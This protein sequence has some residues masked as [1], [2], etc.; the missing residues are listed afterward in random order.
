MSGFSGLEALGAVFLASAAV[1]FFSL[2]TMANPW[3]ALGRRANGRREQRQSR[4]SALAGNPVALLWFGAD[5]L[6]EAT[7]RARALLGL[8]EAGE[9]GGSSPF[10]AVRE[11]GG[12][13]QR[14]LKRSLAEGAA[15]RTVFE[16]TDGRV[17]AAE[18]APAGVEI[19]VSLHDQTTLWRRADEAERR[20]AAAERT[21]E[22]LRA[23]M[24]ATGL[25]V[26]RRD[27][28]GALAE[29]GYAALDPRAQKALM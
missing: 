22:K 18:G 23:A 16:T 10:T 5:G 2:Y 12:E 24:D 7:S 14:A 26:W 28:V 17:L 6:I 19:A 29:P 1:G 20:A 27:G 9:L 4:E 11:G 8:R 15:F 13:L 25:V 21:V 3:R